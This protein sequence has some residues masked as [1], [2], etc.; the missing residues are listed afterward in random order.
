MS[1]IFCHYAYILYKRGETKKPADIH[2]A[3]AMCGNLTHEERQMCSEWNKIAQTM[4][5][6]QYSQYTAAA[7][8]KL[9]ALETKFQC[10]IGPVGKVFANKPGKRFLLALYTMEGHKVDYTRAIPTEEQASVIE[11]D[12][13]AFCVNAGPGTGKSKT[14]ID[15]AWKHRD[16]GVLIVSYAN[17]TVRD[18]VLKFKKFAGSRGII[19]EKDF[20]TKTGTEYKI[21]V[22]TIDSL[23]WKISKR[24]N[25][26]ESSA[27][28]QQAIIDAINAVRFGEKL[29]FKHIIVD[30]SQDIDDKRADLIKALF[31][32][33]NFKSIA[34]FGDPRQRIRAAAGQW[35]TDAWVTSKF[36]TKLYD[37][38]EIVYDES[39]FAEPNPDE[40]QS[41][42]P[43]FSVIDKSVP[44]TKVEFTISHRFKDACTLS[45][46]NCLS[47]LRPDIHVELRGSS[48]LPDNGK[49]RC[50]AIGDGF[51]KFAKYFKK[52]YLDSGYCTTNDACIVAPSIDLENESSL[53]SRELVDSLRSEGIHCYTRAEGSFIPNAIL[54][55][56]IHSV[57]GK[58]FKVVI[59]VGI[60][61]YKSNFPHINPE[62][63]ASLEYV[64]FTRASHENI[65][66]V[67][68][69]FTPPDGIS[70]EMFDCSTVKVRKVVPSVMRPRNF[71]VEKICADHSW[72][73]LVDT[74]SYNVKY[75]KV[76]DILSEMLAS[77]NF[78]KD[79]HVGFQWVFGKVSYVSDS[80]IIQH[81]DVAAGITQQM[82]I[83]TMMLA[84]CLVEDNPRPD[85]KIYVATNNVIEEITSDQ[86]PLLWRYLI[87]CYTVIRN[88]V[89][90][91]S[92]RRNRFKIANACKG[93]GEH[94]LADTEFEGEEIFD[95]AMI[96]MADPFHAIVQP[97]RIQS[98]WAVNWVTQ[99]NSKWTNEQ[100]RK[101]HS[102][103]GK[104]SVLRPSFEKLTAGTVHYYHAPTD[105]RIPGVFGFQGKD[106]YP[107]A[108]AYAKTLGVSSGDT[109]HVNLGELYDSI[110]CP[111]S[112]Q[113][114]LCQHSALT[115]ALLL[116]ELF[117]YGVFQI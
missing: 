4:P 103:A 109:M 9:L 22:T 37:S 59:L 108:C 80:K 62:E 110:I 114:H 44:L 100:V 24:A 82:R 1:L 54:L 92:S 7:L 70:E 64:A 25:I 76:D 96:N 14:A 111:M 15:R 77:D 113:K 43:S 107:A 53:Q 56:T 45:L 104:P 21:V 68:E 112:L 93:V 106:L 38:E 89:D 60:S 97:L 47:N 50:Y 19:G 23:A 12:V 8:A 46:A 3:I 88:H 33:G 98:E 2:A 102:V 67:K 86:H 69:H 32:S 63:S 83:M 49:P 10:P 91:A 99:H 40:Y 39:F 51:H 26:Y 41:N 6:E 78:K 42:K 5:D 18:L 81:F 101:L 84:G 65:I 73:T 61:G 27:S 28:H 11:P 90:I 75:Q 105:V 17:A 72:M 31:A 36:S 58:E 94:W 13:G 34:I 66:L 117:T 52:Y 116:W 55:S 48:E 87:D 115:D 35:F 57:K 79:V 29:R 30:E 71:A 20:A 74:N 85:R 95:F 16:E